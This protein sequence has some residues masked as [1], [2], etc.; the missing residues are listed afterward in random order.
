MVRRTI[1]RDGATI[2]MEL[3]PGAPDGYH[4]RFRCL[5]CQAP[6]NEGATSYIHTAALTV[7]DV[8]RLFEG[9]HV[10]QHLESRHR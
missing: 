10:H 1:E 2:T 3:E 4:A 7:D 9:T 5:T 6:H 8:F